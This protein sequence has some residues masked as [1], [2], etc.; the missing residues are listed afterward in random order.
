MHSRDE[1]RQPGWAAW[2]GSGRGQRS[3]GLAQL[4]LIPRLLLV[5]PCLMTHP[6]SP[7]G[8]QV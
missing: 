6:E 1:V 3:Q 7:G 2:G 4:S 8:I 5:T